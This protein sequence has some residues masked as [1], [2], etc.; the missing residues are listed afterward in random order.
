VRT[1][2][3]I[4]SLSLA[5]GLLLAVPAGALQVRFEP[6]APRQG[7]PVLVIVR[8]AAGAGA[9]SG[10]LGGR[11]LHFFPDDGG[12]AALAGVDLE[13]KP[14]PVAWQ[15]KDAGARAAAGSLG[16]L[17]REFPVERLTLPRGQ[18]DLDPEV[19][20]RVTDEIGRLRAVYARTSGERLW[21]G[22][23][24][25]PVA[26]DGPGR[27]FG[28][29]RI[30]NG[31]ARSPHAGVDFAGDTG[32]PVVAANRG[33]VALVGDFFFP[34]RFVVLDHGLGLYTLY[35]H[36]DRV[37][38]APGALVERGEPIGTV[39][40]TGRATGPH[41]HWGAQV[42]RSRIDPSLLLTLPR[43]AP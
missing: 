40:A 26:G 12:F 6:S 39:G 43:P 4:A 22:P 14:G 27:G 1:T 33:R 5:A 37:D 2:G 24:V 38:A 35:F 36:L 32:T 15:V 28:A 23:F 19:E 8:G 3:G 20:R 31:Q 11:P 17:A 13:T 10:V 18:V 7:D 29:R 25:R 16:V 41:L 42:N 30:L 21:R 9:P 34:G